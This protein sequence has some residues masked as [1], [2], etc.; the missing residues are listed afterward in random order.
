[1]E[2]FILQRED[3][4]TPEDLRLLVH[5]LVAHNASVAAPEQYQPLTFFLRNTAGLLV[6]GIHGQTHWEWLFISHLW[7]HEAVRS[8]GHG[9]HL[10]AAAEQ[11]A[12]TRGCRNAHLDTYS[13]QAREFY[14]KLGYTLFGQL[15]DY[16]P[17]HSRY[18]LRKSLS[19]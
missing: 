17:G 4:P 13:F 14:L 18:F 8:Q 15:E 9:T 19:A 1:M 5:S 11:E 2:N 3:N 7:V 12:L 16:P 6:A 10:I